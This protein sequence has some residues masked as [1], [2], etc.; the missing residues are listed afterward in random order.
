MP[1]SPD[2]PLPPLPYRRSVQTDRPDRANM[3]VL[4][5]HVDQ[6]AFKRL[7]VTLAQLDWTTQQAVTFMVY[8][9]LAEFEKKEESG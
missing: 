8:A 6:A 7:K 4:A 1:G 9:F 5:G 3:R 2:Y